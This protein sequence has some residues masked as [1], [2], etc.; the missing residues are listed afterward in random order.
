MTSHRRTPSRT[1]MQQVSDR[2]PND[3]GVCGE[4]L[5]RILERL[6]FH[7]A[8]HP[9]CSVFVHDAGAMV[10]VPENEQVLRPVFVLAA[11]SHL[12]NFGI[13]KAGVFNRLLRMEKQAVAGSSERENL[14][15]F[16]AERAFSRRFG[17]SRFPLRQSFP[18]EGVVRIRD[19]ERQVWA[20]YDISGMR[21]R[22]ITENNKQE[23]S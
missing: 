14:M 6:G 4:M 9:F 1:P 7:R 12:E 17:K 23:L 20:E 5:I 10:S 11:R 2:N 16:R 15:S 19:S 3:A 8:A 13:L 21:L 18:R 22:R